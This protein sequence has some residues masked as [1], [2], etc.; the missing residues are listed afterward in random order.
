MPLFTSKNQWAEIFISI[1]EWC[2]TW[3][4]SCQKT[5]KPNKSLKLI[6]IQNAIDVSH[7]LSDQNF[8]Y[9]LYGTNNITN[10]EIQSITEYIQNLWRKYKIQIPLSTEYNDIKPLIPSPSGGGLGRGSTGKNKKKI[11]I[12]IVSK[13]ITEKKEI[14]EVITSIKEFFWKENIFVNY[15]FLIDLKYKAVFESI[16]KKEF[17]KEWEWLYHL[18]MKNIRICLRSLYNINYKEQTVENLNLKSCL[19]YDSFEIGSESI[20]IDDHIE[21]EPNLDVTFHNPLCYIWY[22]KISN[23]WQ[24]TKVILENFSRYKNEYLAELNTNMEKSCFKCIRK[25]FDYRK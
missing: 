15:D 7:S 19:V 6:D 8:S 2:P 23:I 14:L 1:W 10:P 3:C 4:Q 21:I 13:K 24:E 11:S 16:L 22:P 12:F 5:L 17:E 18:D 20:D 25:G 9:F